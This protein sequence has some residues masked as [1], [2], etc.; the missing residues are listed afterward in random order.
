MS[1]KFEKKIIIKKWIYKQYFKKA[2]LAS[3]FFQI[4][5][6]KSRSWIKI[7][8]DLEWL[9]GKLLREIPSIEVFY[10][11][12]ESASHSKLERVSIPKVFSVSYHMSYVMYHVS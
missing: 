12:S 4:A 8:R 11:W 6:L 1:S 7:S 5:L 9:S 2:T 3:F 10:T